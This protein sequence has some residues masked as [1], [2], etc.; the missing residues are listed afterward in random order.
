MEG[1]K[2]DP[3]QISHFK[4]V[5]FLVPSRAGGSFKIFAEVDGKQVFVGLVSKEALV[6]SLSLKPN[7]IVEISRFFSRPDPEPSER[8][9]KGI[10]EA[11]PEK[12]NVA[13]ES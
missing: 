4:T 1:E 5:G 12:I 6:K 2:G 13:T 8:C 11:D 10:R 3:K 9:V 7:V